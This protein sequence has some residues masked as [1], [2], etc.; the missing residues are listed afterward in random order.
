MQII[1]SDQ[2]NFDYIW[3]SS[4]FNIKSGP[5]L[6]K[7]TAVSLFAAWTSCV[8][9]AKFIHTEGEKCR[10]HVNLPENKICQYKTFLTFFLVI[11]DW[12]ANYA[13]KVNFHIGILQKNLFWRGFVINN[14]NMWPIFLYFIPLFICIPFK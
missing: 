13:S 12:P 8:N 11:N 3:T 2:I 5:V 4:Q 6:E 10:K 14:K 9:F 7:T 1:K